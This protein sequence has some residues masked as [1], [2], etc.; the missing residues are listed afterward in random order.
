MRVRDASPCSL[1]DGESFN[2]SS[3][4]AVNRRV[5]PS[6]PPRQTS[7]GLGCATVIVFA[8]PQAATSAQASNVAT[9][10]HGSGD[11]DVMS[12]R[13]LSRL[14]SGEHQ[15]QRRASTLAV[16]RPLHLVV[17]LRRPAF[18]A[19]HSGASRRTTHP[20]AQEQ[21]ARATQAE[22]RGRELLLDT[23]PACVGRASG[24]K[25]QGLRSACRPT[26]GT[27]HTCLLRQGGEVH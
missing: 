13:C 11:P 27:T 1:N 3:T 2:A 22:E 26:R 16:A 18:N 8:Q 20:H 25:T 17:G 24:G 10:F 23:A 12:L 15:D 19:T 5:R 7:I 14:Q 4:A 9:R 21:A 6:S